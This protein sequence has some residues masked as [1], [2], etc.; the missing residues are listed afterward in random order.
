MVEPIGNLDSY[1]ISLINNIMAVERQPLTRLQDQLGK[2]NVQRGAYLDLDSQLSDLQTLTKS[3]ISTDASYTLDASYKA[4]VTPVGDFTVLTASASSSAIAGAYVIDNITL[5]RE[6]RVRSDKQT[7]SDQALGLTG[8]M[9][10][11]GASARSQSTTSTIANTVTAFG[12]TAPASGQIELGTETYYV[13]T[14]NDATAGWQFRLVDSDGK[15]ASIQKSSDTS[16][17]TSEWQ[18]IPTGGGV[19]D[20]GRGLTFTFGTDSGLYTAGSRSS[21]NAAEVDYTAQGVSISVASTDSLNSIAA[22]INEATFA[23]G[24]GIDAT[25]VDRQL[26]LAA[27]NTGTDHSVL[28]S[29]T[30]GTVL[31]TLGV[32][33]ALG[34]FKNVMQTALNSSFDV[35]GVTIT[36]SKNTGI[37]DAIT[38]V[39]LNLASDAAGQTA[40]LTISEDTNAATD[41]IN[42]FLDKINSVLLY[43]EEK[44]AITQ[45]TSGSTITYSRGTLAN[46]LVFSDLRTDLISK[47]ISEVT[48]SGSYS[49]LREIGIT[50]DDSL[51]ATIS[52]SDKLDSAL[53]SN[54]DD[55]TALLDTLMGEIDTLLGRF[56]G[57]SS[58]LDN[59][60]ETFDN[61]SNY[62]NSEITD[63]TER[64]GEREET[65]VL[66]FA[67]VQ[68]QLMS[69]TYMQQQWASIAGSV[70]RFV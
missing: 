62:L 55:V 52:D 28:A 46:D 34:A 32:L 9:L 37:D 47:M 51:Q 6:H 64:L 7:Y 19:Y 26:V 21:S 25:V 18:A 31:E 33:T 22:A 29:D 58:Y 61:E 40:T 65:L 1:F 63:L 5:A 3:L 54:M 69:L 11:G 35:N 49:Y 53:M 59:A 36:R 12:V 45:I 20:T 48:N 68:A 39:T 24:M 44:T 8:T 17:Y 23:E 14:R 13:E 56:T 43:L 42:A 27:R 10:L 70:N 41:A 67:E 2:I 57:A 66:Q 30:S 38:G 4:D 50:L 60:V 16:S 15:A